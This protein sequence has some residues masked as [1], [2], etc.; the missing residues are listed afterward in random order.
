MQRNRGLNPPKE[1]FNRWNDFCDA[2]AP[3]TREGGVATRDPKFLDGELIM[4][5]LAELPRTFWVNLVKKVQGEG[6]GTRLSEAWEEYCD[7]NAPELPGQ[8]GAR[9]TKDPRRL[10]QD[11]LVAFVSAT[12][13]HDDQRG[14]ALA[15]IIDAYQF[16][17]E[18]ADSRAP[19]PAQ[20]EAEWQ[21]RRKGRRKGEGKAEGRAESKGKAE[22]RAE[23]RA[24]GEGKGKGSSEEARPPP[25]KGGGGEDEEAAV[26]ARLVR[27]LQR[28]S[29][30]AKCRW[31]TY[32]DEHAPRANGV[33]VR[34]PRRH[35]AQFLKDFLCAQVPATAWALAVQKATQEA[36]ELA[37]RWDELVDKAVAG[38][39]DPWDDAELMVDLLAEGLGKGIEGAAE[40]VEAAAAESLGPE[41]DPKDKEGA[42]AE[43]GEP[44]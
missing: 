16:D 34:D 39:A 26:L 42:A 23:G 29:G 28:G 41:D 18:H 10:P 4:R 24:K 8:H 2:H 40:A 36:P 5:F 37:E 44:P 17:F 9:S 1:I 13:E 25:Q 27:L 20:A 15:D 33:A 12:L 43:D 21:P 7:M 38:S 3:P 31:D 11:F 35:T 19:V 14:S 32:C 22:G 6:K 30:S